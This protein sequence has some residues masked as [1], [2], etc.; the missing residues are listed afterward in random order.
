MSKTYY[1][2]AECWSGCADE[3][4]PYI[5]CSG[6]ACEGVGGLFDTEE[7]A[8]RALTNGKLKDG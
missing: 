7:E 1:V 4:C 5:H 2:N 6:W 3:S 8:E